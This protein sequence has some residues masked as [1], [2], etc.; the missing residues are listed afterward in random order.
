MSH[1]LQSNC[2]TVLYYRKLSRN[3]CAVKS[4][5]RTQVAAT[6]V[7]SLAIRKTTITPL[8]IFPS[9]KS[10]AR[11]LSLSFLLLRLNILCRHHSPSLHQVAHIQFGSYC[12]VLFHRASFVGYF[13][14]ALSAALCRQ[15]HLTASHRRFNASSEYGGGGARRQL[16]LP[17]LRT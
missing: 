6:V 7:L 5:R 12:F 3:P 9:P 2:P 13:S 10:A 15:P 11:V 4:S 8:Y 14:N 1:R 16:P 17:S